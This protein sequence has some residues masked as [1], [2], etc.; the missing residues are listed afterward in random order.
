MVLIIFI[1][2]IDTVY[3]LQVIFNEK[4]VNFFVKIKKKQF[5]LFSNKKL[6][7][8]FVKIEKRIL[9]Y[10]LIKNWSIFSLKSKKK[11]FLFFIINKKFSDKNPYV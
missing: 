1:D 6:F 9:Y 11:S 5:L 2:N 3:G 10:L 8:F 7:D 4:L